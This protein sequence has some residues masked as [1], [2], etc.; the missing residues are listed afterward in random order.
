MNQPLWTDVLST[1][2]SVV[3]AVVAI[4][5]VVGVFMVR[6]QIMLQRR[7][8]HHDLENLYVARYWDV[9]DR[10]AESRSA[11]SSANRAKRRLALEAYL[12]LSEDECD[13]RA[14]DRIT[15]E[16][17]SFWKDGIL[18]SLAKS[19]ISDLLSESEPTELTHL[20]ELQRDPGYEPSPTTIKKRQKLGLRT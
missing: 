3:S 13:L 10:L 16:T 15:D 12:R 7:Q 14:H 9:M 5:A 8:M 18:A 2:A 4:V 20:R 17:W 19:E 11:D 1:W 6:R